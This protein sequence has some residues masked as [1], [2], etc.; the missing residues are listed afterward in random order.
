MDLRD[1]GDY[2]G[3][4]VLAERSL[5]IAE[6]TLGPK[7]AE[8]ARSLHTLAT[9][10]AGLGDYA[11]A[12][13]LFER[14]TRINEEVLRPSNPESARASWF[15]PDLFP[16]S[17]YDADDLDLFERVLAIREK[18][19]GLCRPPYGRKPEQSRCGAV[20]H[21]GLQTNATDV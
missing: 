17:G 1:L 20:Q 2:A 19:C 14:A 13:R 6:R 3:A 5:A 18:T 9:I 16:L 11:E 8:A 7:H 15:I 21:R 10:Y 12:M 4:K